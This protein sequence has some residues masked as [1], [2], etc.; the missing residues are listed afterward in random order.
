MQEY[1]IILKSIDELNDFNV[2]RYDRTKADEESFYLMEQ[3]SLQV[4]RELPSDLSI[5]VQQVFSQRH[6][7]AQ[8]I[9][10]IKSSSTINEFFRIALPLVENGS[11]PCDTV[12]MTIENKVH[13]ESHDDGEVIL[14]SK[15]FRLVRELIKAI[16]IRQEFDTLL[17]NNILDVPNL[18]HKIER[19]N[20]IK[21]SFQTF[22]EILDA[23]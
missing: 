16:L 12:T 19:P 15:D 21:A 20:I 2:V 4:L 11:F 17:L 6:R 7:I 8:R 18:Y 23:L 9:E 5:Q 1:S 22:E 13:L 14:R 10:E 3:S